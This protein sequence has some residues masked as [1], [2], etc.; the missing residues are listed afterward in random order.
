MREQLAT[1]GTK[2]TSKWLSFVLFVPFVAILLSVN[3]QA[4]FTTLKLAAT[5]AAILTIISLPVSYWIAFSKW[6]WKFIIE[7]VV[8]VPLVLPPTVLGFYVL[9]GL[10]PR[11]P[12]GQWYESLVGHGLPFTFEG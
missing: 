5:T 9:M 1:K 8:A 7:A 10:G 2:C 6:R 3:W 12:I 11:S 4:L